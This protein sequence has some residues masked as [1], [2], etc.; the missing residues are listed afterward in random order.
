[1][2]LLI[3]QF[4]LALGA[5]VLPAIGQAQETAA[6]GAPAGHPGYRQAYHQQ[7]QAAGPQGQ[8]VNHSM[9]G[10]VEYHGGGYAQGGG[11]LHHQGQVQGHVM[12]GH[13]G[14]P[15]YGAVPYPKHHAPAA[16][17]YVGAHYPYPQVPLGWKNVELEW[18]DG[19]WFLDF[20]NPKSRRR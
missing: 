18:A 16:W 7:P 20:K 12:P 1:M 5:C 3:F 6:P 19:W 4:A 8:L 10:P 15:S 17:P 13:P 2:R 9:G 11:H 14:H